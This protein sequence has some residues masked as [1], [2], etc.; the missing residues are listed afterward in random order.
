MFDWTNA[1]RVLT[2]YITTA[3]RA[4]GGTWGGAAGN[5]VDY[6]ILDKMA[7]L[8]YAYRL[9]M[10]IH[11]KA[12]GFSKSGWKI[13]KKEF[14]LQTDVRYFPQLNK[15]KPAPPNHFRRPDD[16]VPTE[17]NYVSQIQ[18]LTRRAVLDSPDTFK[19][20]GGN[21]TVADEFFYHRVSLNAY[22][23][24]YGISGRRAM[25]K[26]TRKKPFSAK[27]KPHRWH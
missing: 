17:K 7:V 9:L 24:F 8:N 26:R 15:G 22:K 27:F 21:R 4:T 1:R 19:T 6:R 2:D 23:R 16:Y 20:V 25:E 3:A 5:R 11:P 12:S 14:A 13:N 18:Q 10:D